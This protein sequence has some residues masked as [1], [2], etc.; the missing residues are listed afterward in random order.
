MNIINE[1]E[2]NKALEKNKNPSAKRIKDMLKKA[3]KLKGLDINDTASL[4]NI[5]SKN[6]K[7]MKELFN[8]AFQI[9]NNIYGNRLVLFAPVYLSNYCSNDCLYCGFRNSNK[10]M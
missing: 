9:K 5:S 7:L 2:I 1:E 4:L 6:N 10:Q 8:A 3:L